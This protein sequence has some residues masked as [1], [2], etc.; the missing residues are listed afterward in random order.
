[1]LAS[2]I[3]YKFSVPWASAAAAGY[4]TTSIPASTSS[5][6]ASQALGF[7]PATATPVGAGGTPPSIADVNGALNY[8][9]LW[10]QWYQAGA[11]VGYDATFSSAIGGYPL[12]AILPAAS[13]LGASWLS[14]AD[15]NT[16]NPDTG[17][18][19]WRF[20]PPAAWSETIWIDTG[21]INAAAITL[22]PVP[23]SLAALA[24]VRL[25]IKSV[26]TNTG[27]TNLTINGLTAVAERNPDGTALNPGQI[28]TGGIYSVAYDGTVAQLAIPILPKF[29]RVNITATG[30]YSGNAPSWA[31]RFEAWVTGGGGAGGG[32]DTT[33]SGAGG[34][35]GGTADY[36][37]A[38]T[39]GAAYNGVVGVGG[40]CANV[41]SNGSDGAGS[42]L[43]VG[44]ITYQ[45]N[46][47][48]GGVHGVAPGGGQGGSASGTGIMVIAGGSGTDGA[49]NATT[50]A[51]SGG[52]SF[53]G[54][55]GRGAR[56]Y[57]GG[58][59]GYAF[60]SGGGG[61]YSNG[62]SSTVVGDG[63]PGVVV[64]KFYSS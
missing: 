50:Y 17:G 60:G 34:G 22:V 37:G 59:L 3:P 14:T 63:A 51:G 31:T 24:G 56:T 4:L 5:P 19:G 48:Q 52:A 40:T 1:M 44:G 28:V 26:A 36:A 13:T 20:I 55:G 7:P 64:I 21:G 2:A 54:G 6:A 46:S 27:A 49:T 11:P 23:A 15:N 47:G 10:S 33:Y 12:G 30:A 58:Q 25:Q 62:A 35:A 9:S 18:G 32:G 41:S 61:G 53:W 16:S 29:Q 42:T 57:G 43:I 38:I 45:G 39:G 8:E